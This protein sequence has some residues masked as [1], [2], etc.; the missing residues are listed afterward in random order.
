MQQ[1]L[2]ALL[3][4][5]IATLLNFNQMQAT[6]QNE[7]MKIRAEMQHMALSVAQETMEIVRARAYDDATVGIP[8]DSIV[9]VSEFTSPFPS[10][11]HCKV[12]GGSDV[13]D[14]VDDFHEM[15]PATIPFPTPNGDLDFIV[16]IE[17]QYVDST[18]DPAGTKTRRKE[19]IIWVQDKASSGDPRMNDPI[20]FSEVLSRW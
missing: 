18:M 4:L 14:D 12:F 17:V 11:N 7:Q 2:L 15:K 5:M 3:A 16:E 10:N 1:T 6:V 8:K 19:V 9:D 13:C 20:R